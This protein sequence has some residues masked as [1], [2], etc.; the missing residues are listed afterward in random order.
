[1]P[2]NTPRPEKEGLD[3][4]ERLDAYA[5]SAIAEAL[6]RS[7]KRGWLRLDPSKNPIAQYHDLHDASAFVVSELRRAGLALTPAEETDSLL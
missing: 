2:S 6:L 5:R 7:A 1:M 4:I 3:D